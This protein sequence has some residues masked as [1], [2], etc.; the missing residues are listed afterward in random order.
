MYPLELRI[1][2][3]LTYC[4]MMLEGWNSEARGEVY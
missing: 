2:N 1:K 3:I 4:D